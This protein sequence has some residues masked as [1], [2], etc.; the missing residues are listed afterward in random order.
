[1]KKWKNG[2]RKG[3]YFICAVPNA[4]NDKV[5]YWIS[6]N[7]WVTS[8]YCFSEPKRLG[9]EEEFLRIESEFD[10]YIKLFET[11]FNPDRYD[12]IVLKKSEGWVN[13]DTTGMRPGRYLVRNEAGEEFL[14]EFD[15]A[16]DGHH[17]PQWCSNTPIVAWKPWQ[18]VVGEYYFTTPEDVKARI[19][20]SGFDPESFEY[21]VFPSHLS[22]EHSENMFDYLKRKF[23]SHS[24]KECLENVL[25]YLM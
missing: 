7:G 9:E 22:R 17:E 10:S 23:P 18:P 15:P 12:V 6:K 25:D 20:R 19:R 14:C 8:C 11:K 21:R 24:S 1:M 4:F 3:E 2:Y 16:A 13:A 5:S